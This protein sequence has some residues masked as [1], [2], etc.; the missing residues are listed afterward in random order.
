MFVD[1][2]FRFVPSGGLKKALGYFNKGEYRKA[3]REFEAYMNS[4]SGTSAQDR[5]MV[6]M[7]M[8]ESYVEHA[9]QCIRR[10]KREEAIQTLEKAIAIQPN[11]ADIHAM[12]GEQYAEM[13]RLDAAT[14][15]FKSALEINPAYFKARL[16]MAKCHS[17]RGDDYR[18]IEE[19][20]VCSSSGPAFLAEGI[21]DLIRVHRVGG[22]IEEKKA[23]FSRLLEEKP[24][25]AQISKQLALESIQSGDYE[26][27]T[28]ELKKALSVY[29]HYPDLHNLL[30]IAYANRGMTDD[31]ILEFE[32]ALKI[33]PEY[34]K[35]RINLA[36]ALHEKGCND[37][38]MQHLEMIIELDPENELAVNLLRELQPAR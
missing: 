10:N 33:N 30:G 20:E 36:L 21:M 28:D 4:L 27:A 8:V 19:L 31:A 11:Y 12:L 15:C 32:T 7:Y 18:A 35:A 2:F 37:E 22:S 5:E 23:L 34:L 14:R 29:P 26:S 16:M 1:R 13:G 17:E 3:I 25:S 24:T 38:A 6:R 9:K